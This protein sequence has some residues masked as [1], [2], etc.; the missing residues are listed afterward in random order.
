MSW[1]GTAI[2]VGAGTTGLSAYM[3]GKSAKDANRTNRMIADETNRL[4]KSFFDEGRGSTGSAILP[5]YFNQLEG[6]TLSQSASDLFKATGSFVG[7]PNVQ[8]SRFNES[9]R[10]FQPSFEAGSGLIDDIF[11]GS[12]TN[13]RL[14]QVKP[15]KDARLNAAR[16]AKQSVV[17]GVQ[18][19]LNRIRAERSRGGVSG[20]STFDTNRVLQATVGANQNAANLESLA[21]LENA[22]TDQQIRDAG[23]NLSINSLDLPMLRA[24]QQIQQE[25]LPVQTA[26]DILGARMSP[27]DFFRLQQQT[28]QQDR[29]PLVSAVPGAG[30]V[31][32]AGVGQGATAFANYLASKEIADRLA[33]VGAGGGGGSFTL[34]DFTSA[35]PGIRS[36]R[37]A[38]DVT[39]LPPPPFIA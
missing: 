13:R 12:L 18:E 6:E 21:E 23:L 8:L 16:G 32:L 17:Q 7:D 22:L 33:G 1:V 35:N 28:F 36:T 10:R 24:Q 27:F 9:L 4:N 20:G 14:A 34:D 15:I 19:T 30:Q 11:S 29:P 39:T 26:S 25:L 31:A 37:N 5:T 3:G 38:L 2:V